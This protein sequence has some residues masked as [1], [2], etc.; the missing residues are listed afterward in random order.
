ML[1]HDRNTILN[2]QFYQLNEAA[3]LTQLDNVY[4]HSGVN[5]TLVTKQSTT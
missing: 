2:K 5:E 4:V 1:H 3:E